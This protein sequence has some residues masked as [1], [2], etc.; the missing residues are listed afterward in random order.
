MTYSLYLYY[1]TP[2]AA[3]GEERK[4]QVQL[5]REA[6]AQH[7]GAFVLARTGYLTQPR[8]QQK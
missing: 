1:A 7:P 8:A 2:Q 3:P 4:L 6:A 5:T